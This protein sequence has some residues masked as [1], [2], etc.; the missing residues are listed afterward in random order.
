MPIKKFAARSAAASLLVALATFAAPVQAN[1]VIEWNQLAGQ[2]V[3]GPPFSQLRQHAMVHIAMAD[4]VVA[5][6]GRYE[7]FKFD[8]NG[9]RNASASLAAAQA[10]HDV[11]ESFIV[12]PTPPSPCTALDAI[13]AKLAAD[14][15]AAPPGLRNV[16]VAVGEDIAELVLAWRATDGFAD[17]NP[18]PP[19]FPPALL[20][21]VLPGIWIP[22]ASGPAQFSKFGEVEPFAT[23]SST[24]FL[25]DPPPQLESA[26]YATDFNEVKTAGQR[27]SPFYATCDA[28][29]ATHKIALVWANAAPCGGVTT[30][31]RIWHNVARDMALARQLS[32]V[33]TARLFALLTTAQFDS[34]QTSQNS[35]FVYR[36]WRPETA[37]A[38]A[39]AVGS[40]PDYDD[41]PAT[42]GQSGWVPV[43]T[44]PPYPSYGGNMQC[45]GAG[46]AGIL[47]G[48]FG[49]AHSFTAK[50]Y[51]NNT[52]TSPVVRE[53]S[54]TSFTQ[55]EVEEGNSRVYGGIHFRF[56]NEESIES[57]NAV[58]D[59]VLETKMQRL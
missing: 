57:C 55:L 58:A 17:A 19:A 33:E 23:L 32:L 12:C 47:R 24:Q 13:N 45:I 36:L 50:W 43:L 22:T 38:N 15:A 46:G 35:K 14:L 52:A 31:F 41:N 56:D 44:T 49:D 28:A 26:R 8:L 59:F 25:H 6:H 20:P 18:L 34:V 30:A 27:P 40:D 3:G 10:A 54:Y 11:L 9:N 51:L 4:A 16:S 42:A 29:S 48:L 37:I 39:G 5:I 2:L 21:S 7:P 53:Q 1:T